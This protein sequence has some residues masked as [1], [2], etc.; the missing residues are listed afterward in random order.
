MRKLTAVLAGLIVAM[1]AALPGAAAEIEDKLVIIT[2]FPKDL[3]E[4][5]KAA[6]QEKHPGTAVEVP[7]R[8]RR[9]A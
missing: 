9:P 7:T 8:K 5:F 6:F 2:S 4:P 3:T 1:G